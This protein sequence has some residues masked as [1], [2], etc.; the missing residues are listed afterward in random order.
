[1]SVAGLCCSLVV[2]GPGRQ[3]LTGV[4]EAEEQTLV[5]Q[6]VAHPAVE[7]FHEAVLG[8]VARRDVVPDDVVIRGPRPRSRL[9]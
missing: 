8:W 2:Q 4:V 7:A 3:L 6:L 9:R 1:M 5:Q